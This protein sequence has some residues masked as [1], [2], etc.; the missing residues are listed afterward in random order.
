MED[1][2]FYT[3]AELLRI[4][5]SDFLKLEN[6]EIEII[7]KLHGYKTV[8]KDNQIYGYIPFINVETEEIGEEETNI[9]G[10]DFGKLREYLGY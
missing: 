7:M 4:N 3:A 5:D 6:R 10:Y 2:K 8:L 1:K 9:T